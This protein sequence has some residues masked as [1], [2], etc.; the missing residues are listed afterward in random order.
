[1]P[2][3]F[4][5]NKIGYL[6][7]YNVNRGLNIRLASHHVSALLEILNDVESARNLIL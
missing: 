3:P 6:Q 4:E 2:E 1:M 7:G 5:T